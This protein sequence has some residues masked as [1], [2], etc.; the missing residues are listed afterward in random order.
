MHNERSS[1]AGIERGG[2]RAAGSDAA[3]AGGG[4]GTRRS[5]IA[6]GCCEMQEGGDRGGTGCIHGLKRDQYLLPTS[7]RP[8]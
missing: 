8:V 1:A 6:V 5:S 7:C 4:G 2:S 3:A